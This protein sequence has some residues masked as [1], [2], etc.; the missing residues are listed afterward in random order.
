MSNREWPRYSPSRRCA[1]CGHGGA[2]TIHRR[3]ITGMD[4]F[5][6]SPFRMEGDYILR[7]CRQCSYKWPE[8]PLD[9]KPPGE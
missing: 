4:I 9:R 8:E 1:K 7:I 5:I 3:P 2:G 6:P